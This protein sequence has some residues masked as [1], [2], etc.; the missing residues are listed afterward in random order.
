[1]RV[2]PRKICMWLVCAAAI[3]T[4]AGLA[5]AP[6]VTISYKTHEALWRA[7]RDIV[8]AY[9]AIE[10][11]P[12]LNLP[13]RAEHARKAQELLIE[14]DRELRMAAAPAVGK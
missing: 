1:M 13:G 9:E 4:L 11:S 2:S 12:E 3:E 7:Q 6:T 5:S 8:A 10:G 14:A